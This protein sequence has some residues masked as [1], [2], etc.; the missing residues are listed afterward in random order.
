[1]QE[2]SNQI[3]FLTFAT[4]KPLLKV[5]SDGSGGRHT[6]KGVT[7]RFDFDGL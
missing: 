2:A 1:M 4:C 7:V 6:C 5:P 3:I